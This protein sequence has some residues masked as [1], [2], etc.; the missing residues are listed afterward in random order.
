M[1]A[2]IA[3]QYGNVISH[4]G[5]ESTEIGILLLLTIALYAFALGGGFVYDDE[6]LLVETPRLVT[7]S[8]KLAFTSDFWGLPAGAWRS[9]HYRPVAMLA[10]SGI[11]R[12][13]GLSPF[14]FHAVNILLHVLATLA[15]FYLVRALCSEVALA[16]A[17]LFAV[18]PLHVETV[19]WMSGLTETLVGAAVL[20]SLALFVHRR[21]VLSWTLAVIAMLTKEGALILPVLVLLLP[22][23][24]GR[25]QGPA[26]TFPGVGVGPRLRRA[27]PFAMMALAYLIAR[28][29]VLPRPPQGALLRLLTNGLHDMPG[30]A[31]RYV[32]ALFAPWPMAIH[33]ELPGAKTIGAA[34]VIAI[35]W[36]ALGRIKGM[37]AAGALA[38]LP[39]L[40]PVVTSALMV[41]FVKIQDRYAYISTA[42][43]CLAVALILRRLPARG[44]LYACMLLVPLWALGTYLQ[45]QVW[46]DN[47]S[48]WTHALEVTPSSK[49][50]A[51]NLGYALYTESRFLEAERVYSLALR[52]HPEDQELKKMLF[53]VEREVNRRKLRP[54]AGGR[55]GPPL[56]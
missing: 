28:A 32:T 3:L 18:H 20:G 39:L 52:Y 23:P 2:I 43:A 13:F 47:E 16:A 40:L 48:L 12:V 30:V 6:Q 19:A 53:L 54:A 24:E 21:Y 10:Y 1:G 29:V 15:L 22:D 41:E 7:A 49:P 45:I 55:R 33:Y 44:L 50:A 27:T 25:A 34:V 17:A 38:G 36:F 9:L 35:L 46:Q 26:P 4:R 37:G 14:A 11:Y 56:R 8:V 31:A 51:L 5:T 42:G